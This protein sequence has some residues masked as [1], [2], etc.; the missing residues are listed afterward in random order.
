MDDQDIQHNVQLKQGNKTGTSNVNQNKQTLN[1]KSKQNQQQQ[2]NQQSDQ[3]V[4][5]QKKKQSQTRDLTT[6]Q[7]TNQQLQAGAV[8][9]KDKKT[10][11]KGNLLKKQSQAGSY[12]PLGTRNIPDT[13]NLS[14]GQNLVGSPKST[15]EQSILGYSFLEEHQNDNLRYL[16]KSDHGQGRLGKIIFGHD[17]L[18]LVVFYRDDNNEPSTEIRNSSELEEVEI[19]QQGMMVNETRFYPQIARTS[20]TDD[21]VMLDKDDMHGESPKPSV[22]YP[23]IAKTF[24]TNDT[25][26][27]DKDIYEKSPKLYKIYEESQTNFITI[28]EADD[29][30]L[31]LLQSSHTISSP[32]ITQGTHQRQQLVLPV[33]ILSL[34]PYTDNYLN[35]RSE[36]GSAQIKKRSSLINR[37][38]QFQQQFQQQFHSVIENVKKSYLIRSVQSY[39]YMFFKHHKNK[40]VQINEN[41]TF[42]IFKSSN[43]FS[44]VIQGRVYKIDPK[45][46]RRVYMNI[47]EMLKNT[48]NNYYVID[49]SEMYNIFYTNI[50]KEEIDVANNNTAKKSTLDEDVALGNTAKERPLDEE[51]DV[52]IIVY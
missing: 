20:K 14:Y 18:S 5:L 41:T 52:Y 42:M 45:N 28:T 50:A 43:P 26:M 40:S 6:Q 33:D 34:V 25:V 51:T 46:C 7:Q 44:S 27:L 21:T 32:Y 29:D 3:E 49:V 15:N 48:S 8:Q 39:F 35:K 9:F 31:S 1:V 4:D 24:K 16:V 38:Q 36:I 2:T 47:L 11:Q 17:G 23:E 37:I 30:N 19:E 10:K 13:S 12:V 22:S